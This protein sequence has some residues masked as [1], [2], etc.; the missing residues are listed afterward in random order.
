[1]SAATQDPG[2]HTRI[3]LTVFGALAVLTVVTVAIGYM[4]LPVGLGITVALIIAAIKGSLV[5]AVFMHLLSEVKPIYW[6]LIMTIIF[7]LVMF[8]IF[9]GSVLDQVGTPLVS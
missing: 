9:S 7:L 1:M 2:S 8:T 6:L 3:Y 4:S 5:D